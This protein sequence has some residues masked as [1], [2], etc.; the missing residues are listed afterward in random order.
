MAKNLNADVTVVGYHGRKGVK[1]DPTLMGTAVQYLAIET[2]N[3]VMI[4]KDPID[5]K[6]KENESFTFAACIDGSAE[7]LH[8]INYVAQIRSRQD[9]VKILVVE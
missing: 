4:L 9:K 3:P 2:A 7:S 1:T 5:R 6:N 8:S